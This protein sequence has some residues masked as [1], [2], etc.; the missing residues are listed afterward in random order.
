MTPAGVFFW[1]TN[2][3]Y[4]WVCMTPGLV[5]GIFHT[6][7]MLMVSILFFAKGHRQH[8]TL[9]EHYIASALLVAI[10]Y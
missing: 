2:S 1:E 4:V 9:E 8:D 5:C 10:I 7:I 3:H 6:L